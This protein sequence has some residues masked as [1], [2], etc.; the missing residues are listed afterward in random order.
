MSSALTQLIEINKKVNQETTFAT[1][2]DQYGILQH[3]SEVSPAG[4][5]SCVSYSLTKRRDLRALGWRQEDLDLAICKDMSG[6]G[7][8]VLVAHT[9]AHDYVLDN[10]TDEVLPWEKVKYTWLEVTD[11]GLFT[12]WHRVDV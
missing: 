1:D 11:Q 8:M 5:G 6:H 4:K 9:P 3:W 12:D 7:H 10:Q 2:L